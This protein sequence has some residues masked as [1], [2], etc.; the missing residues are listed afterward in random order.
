M[1]FHSAA[2]PHAVF[3]PGENLV[4]DGVPAVPA[5]LAERVGRYTEFRSAALWDWHPVEREMLVGTRFAD[6]VQAHRVR[7]PGGARTQV[8]FFG[9]PVASASFAPARGDCFVF[10]KDR[11]G[12]ER[13]QNYR[14]D[15]ATGEVT[16]LS[17]GAARNSAGVWSRAG[18]RLAYTSTRRNGRDVD[19][20][21]VDPADPATD[22][23][24][25]APGGEGWSVLDWSADDGR[26]LVLEY[27]SINESY[28]W[29]LDVGV[30]EM[31]ILTAK[32]GAEKVSYAEGKF[33]GDGRAVYTATDRDGE[34][35]QLVEVD[36]ETGEHSLLTPGL[37]WG[38]EE[39]DLTRDGRYI[40]FTTN[41]DGFSVLRLL[42]VATGQLTVPA[43]VPAGVISG[44]RWH[45]NGRELGFTLASAR[46]PAD[47]YSL[48]VETGTVDRWTC[49]ETGGLDAAAFAEPERIAW[50]SFDGR[51]IPGFLYP[52]PARFDGPR[53]VVIQIHGGPE[54]QSRPGFLLRHNFLLNELGVAM[55]F[56]NIRGSA[57]Y[58][59][60]YLQLD[61]GFR[62]EDTYRDIGALLEWI[63]TR[64]ELDAERVMVTGTSYG[65]HMT[66]AVAT[67]YD[68]RIRCS[69]DIVGPSNLVTLLENTAEYRKDQRRA[70]YGD[71]RDPEMRAFLDRTA[72]LNHAE[73][74][75]KPLFVIQGGND[76]RVPR[77]ESE[78]MV[79]AVRKNGTPV[80]YLMARDEGHGFAKKR[81]VD[82]QLVATVLFMEAFLLG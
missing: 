34:F 20:Y 78:Q 5:A 70:E 81:N 69:V 64:P 63:R 58:G 82:Y 17:D 12:D 28:L 36:L 42:N 8:T 43:G 6:A 55:I 50:E 54:S 1:P 66:L 68:D 72:P 77:S 49:S 10:S 27:L 4:I 23:L 2:D 59:K 45:A 29:L 7:F 16:L 41:E 46:S 40:A 22:R 75:T 71:E 32:G 31:A 18:D 3:P 62:R 30:G 35:R 61:N 48:N 13:Y 53:P 39:F 56:P 26:L 65:G 57:G 67:R 51:R 9:D 47:V 74:I 33:R 52:P 15:L 79:T 80:W 44:L 21:V 24:L 76:P 38:V 19:F 73:Q 11:G 25:A 60:T 14:C 37:E